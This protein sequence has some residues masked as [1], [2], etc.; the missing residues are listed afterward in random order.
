M[1]IKDKQLTKE[2]SYIIAKGND[3]ITKSRFSLTLQ[4]QKIL[5]YFISQ[6]KPTDEEGTMYTLSIK[7]FAKVCGYVEDSGYYYQTIKQDIVAMRNAPARGKENWIQQEDGSEILFSWIDRAKID[8]KKGTVQ[9]SFHSSVSQYL[10]DLKKRYTQYS[11][12]N[13]LCLSHKYSIRLYEYLMAEK[14]KS[15]EIIISLAD[16][17]YRIDAEGYDKFS[18]FRQ[19]VLEPAVLDIND[20]TDLLVEYAFK[21]TGRAVTHIVFS[22]NEKSTRDLVMTQK[23]RDSQIRPEA[24]AN[25][26]IIKKKIEEKWAELE[27]E[28]EEFE[29]E[30]AIRAEGSVTSQMSFDDLPL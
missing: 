27:K 6:I 22:V 17:K 23:L 13:V 9:I 21:K 16:L 5:L 29:Q 18:H 28:D 8:R 3:L 26:R 19:R 10:F 15:Q 4:Q 11:L 20:Y 14:Y 30:E 25:K 12:Y 24:R 2:R 1:P 7:D